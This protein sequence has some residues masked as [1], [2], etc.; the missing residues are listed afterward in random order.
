MRRFDN[1]EG[2]TLIELMVVLMTIALLI[3]IAIPTFLGSR[4][5]AQDTAAHVT[6]RTASKDAYLVVLEQG[7]LPGRP[8]LLALLPTLEPNIDWMDH[9]DSS[10][11]P[12]QVSIAKIGQELTMAA[13]SESGSCF[14][15]RVMD[16]SP[17]AQGF[18][19]AAAT[20]EA[21]D[22]RQTADTGW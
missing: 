13:L 20:C 17:V 14:W 11:G 21:F 22:Y 1:S 5:N 4:D 19:E 8:A 9:K 3:A 12:R 15:L 16:G 2:F 10:T 7:S 6:L 18:V